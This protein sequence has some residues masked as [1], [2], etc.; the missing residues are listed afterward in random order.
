MGKDDDKKKKKAIIV[1][2]A[3]TAD[4]LNLDIAAWAET[5]DD[6][7]V[8]EIQYQAFQNS[9]SVLIG[10]EGKFDTPEE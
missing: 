6:L 7:K 4:Q 2:E 8:K 10:F 9:Y 3:T 1:L 5:I